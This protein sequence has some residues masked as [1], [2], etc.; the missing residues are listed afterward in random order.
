MFL[1]S[2]AFIGLDH[3]IKKRTSAKSLGFGAPITEKQK[4]KAASIQSTVVFY[5]RI[6]N[7]LL[8]QNQLFFKSSQIYDEYFLLVILR[9]IKSSFIFCQIRN[10]VDRWSKS[11]NRSKIIIFSKPLFS[12]N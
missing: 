1:A 10:I 5:L 9:L 2:G 8:N 11:V 12:F 7:L 4:L 3:I 6:S